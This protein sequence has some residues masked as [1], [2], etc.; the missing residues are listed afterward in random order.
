MRAKFRELT[1]EERDRYEIGTEEER[2]AYREAW[3]RKI[4]G[5]ERGAQGESEPR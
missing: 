5:V 3:E 2:K 1:P 4:S